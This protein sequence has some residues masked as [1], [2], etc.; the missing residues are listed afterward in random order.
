MLVERLCRLANCSYLEHP[1]NLT[2]VQHF[3][4]HRKLCPMSLHHHHL[5]D[6][7]IVVPRL[8]LY[9]FHYR[10]SLGC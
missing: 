5:V 7:V 4:R 2:H 3:N 9:E 8:S 6:N 1:H 10:V